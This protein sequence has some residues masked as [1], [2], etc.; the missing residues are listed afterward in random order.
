M[1]TAA[2]LSLY[3]ITKHTGP[4]ADPFYQQFNDVAKIYATIASDPTVTGVEMRAYHFLWSNSGGYYAI[5]QPVPVYF[6]KWQL[7]G[8]APGDPATAPYISHVITYLSEGPPGFD[9][10]DR[11]G[12]FHL[13]Q[14]TATRVRG[15]WEDYDCHTPL[16]AP[17]TLSQI[18]PRGAAGHFG[19]CRLPGR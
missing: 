18:T 1:L 9:L 13:W 10:Q 16:P 2:A 15:G 8:V 5:H 6:Q 17:E 4:R 14:N 3:F 12:D 11:A 7:N 19:L